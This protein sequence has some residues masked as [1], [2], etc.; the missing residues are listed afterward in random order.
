MEDLQNKLVA[1]EE[2][3][4]AVLGE[5][6]QFSDLKQS[7]NAADM[8]LIT[9]SEKLG[10]LAT[11]LTKN[12]DAMQETIGALRAAIDTIKL[13][14]PAK[15]ID[16]QNRIERLL[17]ELDINLSEAMNGVRASVM[18]KIGD[19]EN[20]LKKIGTAEGELAVALEALGERFEEAKISNEE[21]LRGGR[22]RQFFIIALLLCN[23]AALLY[24]GLKDNTLK[25]NV[26]LLG[27]TG[28]N[29]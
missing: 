26:P 13:T 6:K 21:S 17:Q 12:A 28:Q 2:R 23:L 29:R 27:T 18:E 16:A 15:V 11:S 19:T 22:S 9:S 24:L 3:V 7:L 4:V 25:L 1:T 14:D 20:M 5:L 10:H 8:S